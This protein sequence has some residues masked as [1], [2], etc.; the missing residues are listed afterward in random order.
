MEDSRGSG[1]ATLVATTSCGSA[2]H[3]EMP[4]FFGRG[5]AAVSREWRG[6]PPPEACN[7]CPLV[8]LPSADRIGDLVLGTRSRD[9]RR[10]VQVPDVPDRQRRA[11]AGERRERPHPG[12]KGAPVPSGV[13]RL[14]ASFCI[15]RNL[16]LLHTDPAYESFER[17]LGLKVPDPAMPM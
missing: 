13:Q 4:L 3:S 12:G 5:G 1:T 8:A 6:R 11:G 14:I 16:A 17:Y 2:L 10:A 7:A 15:Q 9:A